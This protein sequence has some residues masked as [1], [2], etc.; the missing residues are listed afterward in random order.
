MKSLA[1]L[2]LIGFLAVG[3]SSSTQTEA[4]TALDHSE[5]SDAT[6][7]S[8]DA[9]QEESEEYR[10]DASLYESSPDDDSQRF[11]ASEEVAQTAPSAE[12]DDVQDVSSNVES[13]GILDDLIGSSWSQEENERVY[14]AVKELGGFGDLAVIPLAHFSRG[15]RS[16]V[17][18]WPALRASGELAG[19]TVYGFCVEDQNDGSF[20]SCGQPWVVNEVTSSTFALERALGGSDYEVVSNQ[21]SASLDNIGVRLTEL[22]NTFVEAASEGDGE[23]QFRTAQEFLQML[24]VEDVAFD[25]SLVALLVAAARGNKVFHNIKTETGDLFANITMEVRLNRTATN[26]MSLTAQHD[27]SSSNRWRVVDYW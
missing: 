12:T 7:D 23:V 13:Q 20:A 8:I 15:A 11:E 4:Q 16:V 14:G 17:I 21:T 6:E 10:Q 5:T 9:N 27:E 3:C 18:A 25:N 24:P 1:S 19:S 22:G 2:I 26:V